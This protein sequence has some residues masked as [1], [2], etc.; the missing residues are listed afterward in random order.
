MKA[1]ELLLPGR[2]ARYFVVV[3]EG[4]GGL[5]ARLTVPNDGSNASLYVFEPDGKPHR[6]GNSI[7]AGGKDSATVTMRVNAE[8]VV[9]GVYEIIV[10]APPSSPVKYALEITLPHV[11]VTPRRVAGEVSARNVGATAVSARLEA[12]VVGAVHDTQLV[13]TGSEPATLS[14]SVPA[15]ADRMI[16]DV[17]FDRVFWSTVTDFG[18]T[19]FGASGQV[20]SHGPMN[21]AFNRQVIKLDS[22]ARDQ[23]LTIELF[24][25]FAHLRGE[26]RWTAGVR[27]ALLAATPSRLTMPDA[28][29]AL[30]L[31]PAYSASVKLSAPD[32]GMTPPEGFQRLV[33]TTVTPEGGVSSV[34]QEAW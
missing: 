21:Y 10:L 25:A 28:A 18:L 14:V 23:P 32:P 29:S 31:G 13:G 26:G 17:T 2:L 30:T 20:V 12:E 24:P 3:P 19:V 11:V 34:R 8:D 33:R 7:D 5:T 22:V 9:P 15:W 6:G 27:V 16:V 1:R 4:A